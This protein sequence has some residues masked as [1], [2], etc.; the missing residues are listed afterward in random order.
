MLKPVE[1]LAKTAKR[2]FVLQLLSPFF[3]LQALNIGRATR[4]LYVRIAVL[5][6]SD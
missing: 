5:Q 3:C 2:F 4:D 1:R 6:S